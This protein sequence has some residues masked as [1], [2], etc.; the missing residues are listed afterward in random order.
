MNKHI[1]ILLAMMLAMGSLQANPVSQQTAQ[2]NASRFVASY[3]EASRQS[4]DLALVYTARAERGEATFYVFNVGS[5]GF[6][7]M[8]ADDHSRPVLGYSDEGVFNPDDM[9]PATR[10]FLQALSE[11]IS[12]R[13]LQAKPS[14][15]VAADWASL[16]NHGQLMSRNGGR[17]NDYLVETKWNQNYPYNYFC[18]V[19]A[20]GPGGHAYAGC[21]AT[22]AAQ[23][24]RYWNHPVQGQGQFCYTHDTYGELCA[25]F[26]ETTYD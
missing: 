22:A 16:E 24:V 12:Y 19:D 15:R 17:I 18:P 5:N 10:D 11:G 3:F 2:A 4:S 25:N 13:S 23:L 9:A 6:V 26:G 7:V 1:V 8:S 20:E 21:V 14:I